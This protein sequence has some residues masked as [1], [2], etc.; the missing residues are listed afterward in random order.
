MLPPLLTW[1][2]NLLLEPLLLLLLEPLPLLLLLEPLPPLL[3][4]L[5]L[6]LMLPLLVLLLMLPLP[7]LGILLPLPDTCP[8]I[9]HFM[10]ITAVTISVTPLDKF[11]VV[12]F[13]DDEFF[14]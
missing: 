13:D 4:L 3:L 7:L 6:L 9:G 12:T 5:V 11:T 2:P 8:R 14:V 10:S 1:L